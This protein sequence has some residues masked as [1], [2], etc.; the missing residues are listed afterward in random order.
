MRVAVYLAVH[1][2]HNC[3]TKEIDHA[4]YQINTL[5]P[6]DTMVVLVEIYYIPRAGAVT[7][8]QEMGHAIYLGAC[9]S[10]YSVAC[11]DLKA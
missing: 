7:M 3:M 6:F 4:I 2:F 9:V 8:T 10:L 11:R 1:S 5:N